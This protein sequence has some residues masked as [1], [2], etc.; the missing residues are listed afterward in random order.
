MDSM[1]LNLTRGSRLSAYMGLVLPSGEQPKFGPNYQYVEIPLAGFR[2][3][4]GELLSEAKANQHLEVVAACTLNVRG[5]FPVMVHYN[6]ALQSVAS[7]GSNHII[8]PGGDIL[9][10]TYFAT[11]RKGIKGSELEWAVRLSLLA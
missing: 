2:S 8:W 10:P 6:P 4:D 1:F 3:S 11:F 9:T 7:V 5:S